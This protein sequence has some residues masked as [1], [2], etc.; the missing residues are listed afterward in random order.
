M[1]TRVPSPPAPHTRVL[2]SSRGVGRASTRPREDVHRRRVPGAQLGHAFPGLPKPVKQTAARGPRSG[3]SAFQTQ[4]D[5]VIRPCHPFRAPTL[6]SLFSTIY[7]SGK[8]FFRSNRSEG[9]SQSACLPNLSPVLKPQHHITLELCT[10]KVEAVGAVKAS[11]SYKS[12]G[13]GLVNSEQ[14]K[15]IELPS[16]VT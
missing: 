13:R 8:A 14:T 16:F 1:H 4:G 11:L 15:M 7:H 5:W 3:L 6:T 9:V 12:P 2:E 10:Q